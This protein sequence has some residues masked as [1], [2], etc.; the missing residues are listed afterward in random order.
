MGNQN[1]FLVISDLQVP[2]QHPASL[3]FCLSIVREYKIPLKNILNVGD[4]IDGYWGSSYNKSPDASMTASGEIEAGR[5]IMREWYKAFPLMKLAV[6]NHGLRWAKKASDA[7][8]PSQL[9]KSYREIIDAP[10]GWQWK[11]E[12]FFDVEHPFRMIHGMG[13]SGKDGARNAAIDSN[14]STVIGHLHSFAGIHYIRTAGKTIWGMNAGC[15]IDDKQYAFEY[16]KYSRNKPIISAA[17]ILDDGR[18][19]IV[20]P[21][22]EE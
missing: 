7:E 17:V 13:Y 16:G 11:D 2:F 12:W 4:E 18:L 14:C 21:F 22:K 6:S 15:L 5:K 10:T 9:L 1:N 3:F 19:P 20:I 8:I